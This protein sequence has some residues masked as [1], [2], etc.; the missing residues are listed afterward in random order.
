MSITIGTQIIAP[1]GFGPLRK[2]CI[3]HF[4]RSNP[5]TEQ[6]LLIEYVIR[7][8]RTGKNG[9][10]QTPTP[11]VI[12]HRL[13]RSLFE[14]AIAAD[15]KSLLVSSIQE[16]LPPWLLH[17]KEVN[18]EFRDGIRK[19]VFSHSARIQERLKAISPAL[20]M[21][22]DIL[23]A[24]E[25]DLMLN[26][27]AYSLSPPKNAPRYRLWFYTFIAYGR[28]PAALHYS[29]GAIGRW[30]RDSKPGAKRGAPS[31]NGKGF[32]YNVDAVMREKIL[33]GYQRFASLGSTQ[34]DIYGKTLIDIFRCIVISDHNGFLRFHQP[35]GIPI[36][37]ELQFRNTIKNAYGRL[38]VASDLDGP[39]NV[40]SQLA[41]SLGTFSSSVCNLLERVEGDG[42]FL[43]EL[44]K[45][46][47]EG[48]PLKK[49]AVVRLRCV[50]S[51]LMIGIGF[52]L[53]G[54]KASAYRMALFCAAI[55]KVR[56]CALFGIDITD[57]EWPGAGVPPYIIIDRGPGSGLNALSNIESTMPTIRE[58][59]PSYAGQSKATIETTNPKT[60]KNS[61]GPTYIHSNANP[62]ELVRK[63]I[64]RLLRDNDSI[65][66]SDRLTPDLVNE[67]RKPS[68]IALWNELEKR[69]RN[70][71]IQIDFSKAVR[72]FLLQREATVRAD[73]IEFL[74]RR[75]D[76]QSLRE[77]DILRRVSAGMK[78]KLRV[79]VMPACVRHIWVDIHDQLI[80]VNLHLALRVQSEL[81]YIALLHL[82]QWAEEE[83]F[84]KK[85]FSEH[86]I[87]A[88]QVAQENFRTETGKEWAGGQKKK[89]NA[90]RGKKIAHV[91]LSESKRDFG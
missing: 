56:F 43:K 11:A 49:L 89:G 9:K 59:T 57:R 5:N 47:I 48:Y 72:S 68:S 39:S 52:S 29:T 4:L 35:Q 67:V 27:I 21:A 74:G 85:A 84:R 20:E 37:S 6:V 38:G 51:G 62:I 79:Y 33:E 73:G 71:S 32:G 83:K 31:L 75:Y 13:P 78:P 82:E 64:R 61:E 80:E 40:R 90:P 69:G 53:G 24:A 88:N 12:L 10:R 50:A 81:H 63:E 19:G 17:L 46:L 86:R 66:I 65:D 54:E 34:S 36:P 1:S 18:L 7:Q 87:A 8:P 44:P 41:P 45:G 70:D 77:C 42:Y 23:N 15:A 91:E 28:N 22:D 30:D 2:N 58:L 55:G 76:S 60:K 3:Y 26:K 16:S 14:S 25:P